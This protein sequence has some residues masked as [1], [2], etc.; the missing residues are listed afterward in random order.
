MV[1][2]V[3]KI[4]ILLVDDEEEFVKALSERIQLRDHGSEIALSGEQALKKIGEKRPDVMVLDLK[5]PGMNGIEVLR[6][7]RKAYPE[8][9][10]IILTGHG[11]DKD[12]E[13]ALRLGAFQYLKKPVKIEILMKH[14]RDAYKSKIEKPLAAATFAEAGEFDTAKDILG[15]END[16]AEPTQT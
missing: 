12:E 11:T 6:H 14:V 10:V 5:M 13:E 3:S 1:K 8:L 7:V 16:D 2:H 9:P 4:N 15:T